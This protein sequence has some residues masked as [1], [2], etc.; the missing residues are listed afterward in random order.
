MMIGYAFKQIRLHWVRTFFAMMG[1]IIGTAAFV[2]LMNIGLIFQTQMQAALDELG[3]N[4]QIVNI[5]YPEQNPHY[6]TMSMI[7][8]LNAPEIVSVLPMATKAYRIRGADGKE[9][10][11]NLLAL[12]F[13]QD[14]PFKVQITQGRY[15][16][17]S[18]DTQVMISQPLQDDLYHDTLDHEPDETLF[19]DQ[20]ILHV[21]GVEEKQDEGLKNLLF[22]DI[23]HQVI[24][25]LKSALNTIPDLH[26]DR[27]VIQFE[28][29]VSANDA[30]TSILFR[31][32]NLSPDS[33]AFIQNLNDFFKTSRGISK[34]FSLFLLLVGC[35][36]LLIGG[37]GIMNIMLVVVMERRMEIGLRMAVGANG[38]QIANLFLT[39][40]T[41]ICFTGGVIGLICA[42]PFMYFYCLYAQL[43]F[44]LFTKTVLL[45]LLVPCLI[46]LF[47]GVFP[48][49]RATKIDPILA[50]HDL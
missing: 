20:Q 46:G 41:L 22:G 31:L 3:Q 26:I 18:D 29:D 27:L 40:S 5:I 21:I 11:L 43:P 32:K 13:N 6:L 36:A 48:A 39:E 7:E 45:G 15:L 42:L 49:I 14:K 35:I 25:N 47:F 1:I 17:P 12:P 34:Q 33:Q 10:G 38:R 16:I 9:V 19:L 28:P 30:K 24:M 44:M 37:I 50:L 23:N 2:G 4:I 8:S